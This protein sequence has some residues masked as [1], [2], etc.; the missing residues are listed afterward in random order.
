MIVVT[1]ATGSIGRALV[2]RLR[3]SGAEVLALVRRAEQGEELGVDYAVGDFERPSS[4]PMGDRLFLNTSPWPGFV[5]R[6]KE[7]IDRA[8][9][10]GV[11]QVVS[12]SVLGATPGA[13]LS[14]GPARRGRRAPQK[15]GGGPRHPRTRGLHAESAARGPPT[16][17]ST[18]RTA[19]AAPATSTRAT[20][21]T[22]PSLFSPDPWA[23]AR[24]MS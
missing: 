13:P 2:A 18:A 17:A 5:Q 10:E 23:R 4:V 14:G 19:R 8:V 11:S 7:V 1:G 12:V 20:S 6:H 21:P 3:E 16:G 22:S 15:V 9:A 24:P